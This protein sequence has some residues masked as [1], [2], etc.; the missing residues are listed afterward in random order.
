MFFSGI[1]YLLEVYKLQVSDEKM[2]ENSTDS[3]ILDFM[4]VCFA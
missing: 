3:Y 2:N 1:K 4:K